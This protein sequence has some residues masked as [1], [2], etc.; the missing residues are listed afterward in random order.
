MKTITLPKFITRT[1]PSTLAAV[2]LLCISS[3]TALAQDPSAPPPI[4][5]EAQAKRRPQMYLTVF[6]NGYGDDALPKEPAQ[7]EKLVR[8]ISTQG[9]FNAIMCTYSAER[10]EICKKRG[11]KMIV[12]LLAPEHHLYKNAKACEELCIR[13]R[14]DPTVVAYHL[15]A[16]KF[17]KQGAGRA[18]DINNIHQWDPTHAT[19]TGTYM[20]GGIG[21]L[22]A[23]DFISY[24]DF[25]WKRGIQKNF[26][27]LLGAWN[28]AKIHDNRLGRYVECDAGLPGKGNFNRSLYTQNT[29]IACGL[30]AVLWFIGSGQMNMQSLE[31]NEAGL[32]AAKVNAWLKPLWLEIPKLGL[33]TAIYAT[34]LTKDSNDRPVVSTGQ[35]VYAPGL[36]S[37]AIP[38]D[39]WIQAVSGEFV[40]G[41]SK[42]DGT[43]TDAIYLANLNAYNGQDVK[44][45]LTKPLKASIFSRESGKYVE[46]K[47]SD[48]QIGFKLE[49]GGGALVRFQ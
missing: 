14:N 6:N 24:Y 1:N 33:P 32:D 35:P 13:L 43:A 49:P 29:S 48:G 47:Q 5:K 19:Y 45:K 37:C 10:L 7:F 22:A 31:F 34:P 15:W 39:F 30:R 11:I 4:D 9:K 21:H 3:A 46:L 42:Y 28:Q 26:P 17:G 20:N 8:T 25:A 41:V 36:E 27:H 40:M 16:D 2:A 23:S 18:R 38:A 12:D 44:L